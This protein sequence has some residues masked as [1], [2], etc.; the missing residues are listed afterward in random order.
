MSVC[1]CVP[2]DCC[3]DMVQITL[4]IS[5]EGLQLFWGSVPPPF[6]KKSSLGNNDCLPPLYVFFYLKLNEG[7]EFANA[8]GGQV[9]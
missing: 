7:E 5:W 3:T 8:P 2:K 4:H 1:V 6:H 9:A